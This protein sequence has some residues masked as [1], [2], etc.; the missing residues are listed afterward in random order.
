MRPG[1]VYT[2]PHAT[3]LAQSVLLP[4]HSQL[5]L[6]HQRLSGW[7]RPRQRATPAA[8]HCDNLA[9]LRGAARQCRETP[10][11]HCREGGRAGGGQTRDTK[12]GGREGV[13]AGG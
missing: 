8:P 11:R 13:G 6:L 4:L 9:R 3:Q 12:T 7:L 1:M 10:P 5:V 2:S